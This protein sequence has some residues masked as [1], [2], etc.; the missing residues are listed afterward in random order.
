M[1]LRVGVGSW[2]AAEGFGL[3][4]IWTELTGKC[5]LPIECIQCHDQAGRLGSHGKMT[6]ENW[7]D[8]ID[9]A[10]ASYDQPEQF[11]SSAQTDHGPCRPAL[12]M[13]SLSYAKTDSACCGAPLSRPTTTGYPSA[14]H[15][16]R[17][18]ACQRHRPED[19]RS[20]P[21]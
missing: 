21:H 4:R 18:A 17:N 13:V 14:Q 10:K 2:R 20:G 1:G 19:I 3:Q 11:C 9:Q 7:A 8:L 12:R 5:Q 16:V 6:A 15:R